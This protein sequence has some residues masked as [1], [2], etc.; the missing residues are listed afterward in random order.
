MRRS[1]GH[2]AAVL[3]L[4]LVGA[5]TL[6]LFACGDRTPPADVELLVISSDST[7]WVTSRGG[8]VRIR[9]A[10]M[11]V[12]S[13]DGK[14]RELYVADDDR[15]YL[16]ALFVGFRLFSR[17]L[18]RGD[19]IELRRDSVVQFLAKDYARRHPGDS[20]LGPDEPENDNPSIRAQADIEILGLHGS[21]LSYE[22]H[23]DVDSHGDNAAWAAHRHAVRRGVVD[24]RTGRDVLL[25]DLFPRPTADA[26]VAAG[27]AEWKRDEVSLLA[28]RGVPVMRAGGPITGVDYEFDPESF[29]VGSDG[30]SPTIRFAIPGLSTKGDVEAIEM[31]SRPMAAPAWWPDV[32]GGLPRES[33]DKEIWS[34][35]GDTLVVSA[36]RDTHVWAMQLTHNAAGPRAVA[37]LSSGVERVIW[38]DGS[39]TRAAREALTRAFAEA[40]EYDGM[41]QVAGAGDHARVSLAANRDRI[42]FQGHAT[43]NTATTSPLRSRVAARV[44]GADDAAGR[45]HPRPRIRWR[46]PRN[47]RQDRVRLRD[48]T[49]A[50][51][52]RHRIG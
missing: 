30:Q 48:A 13:V 19:S 47:A 51:A 24:I 5:A 9:G 49:F 23:T 22:H 17:D 50:D 27:R 14:F 33:G 42:H 37:R 44:V 18:E 39:V 28:A 10:P 46:D 6:V 8:A 52:V 26:A 41:G 32:A 21:F 34:R 29:S 1:V 43:N 12:A 45:E 31:S 11:L 25:A 38:L 3:R 7:F 2:F 35:A 36:N 4:A 20:V 15:S 16:D 40:S